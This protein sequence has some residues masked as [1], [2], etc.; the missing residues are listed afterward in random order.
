MTQPET[1]R[2]LQALS[3]QVY[4]WLI[5]PAETQL[6]KNQIGT[7]VFV[8]DEFLKNIPMAALYDGKHYLI[9]NY[10][11][12]LTPGLELLEPQLVRTSTDPVA[13]WRIKSFG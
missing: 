4:N 9:E 13:V 7:L 3:K 6:S 12:A 10:A 2:S 1:Q 5:R 11:I 8:L